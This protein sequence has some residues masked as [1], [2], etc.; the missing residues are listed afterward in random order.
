MKFGSTVLLLSEANRSEA[1]PTEK[2]GEATLCD[3]PASGSRHH[4]G[5]MPEDQNKTLPPSGRQ[6]AQASLLLPS[7]AVQV[8]LPLCLQRPAARRPHREGSI[9][10]TP[11]ATLP[12]PVQ[13]TAQP[14]QGG[15]AAA[16]APVSRSFQAPR[17]CEPSVSPARCFKPLCSEALVAGCPRKHLSFASG[18]SRGR[19]AGAG[20][21]G[22][23]CQ[24]VTA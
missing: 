8:Y 6:R 3:W 23:R 7:L 13:T 9:S 12:S 16:P 15:R 14:A 10:V 2:V 22:V 18:G 17:N 21:R 11:R 24:A 5:Q 1:A 4:P 19:A 20:G